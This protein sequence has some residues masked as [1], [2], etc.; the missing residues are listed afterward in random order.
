MGEVNSR[1]TTYGRR[2]AMKVAVAA[3]TSALVLAGA[4]ACSNSARSASSTST[5]AQ[6]Q[7]A[8]STSATASSAGSPAASGST[9]ASSTTMTTLRLV[10]TKYDAE[11]L[12]IIAGMERGVFKKH[13]IDLQVTTANTS[14]IATSALISNR[15]DL[16]LMQAAFVVSA[17]A[18]GAKIQLIGQLLDQLDYHIITAKGIK[19]L[20]ALAGQKMADPG[21]NNGNTATLKAVMDK[22]GIGADK[23]TYVTVGAQS[24]ILAAIEQNQAQVGL[25]VAPFTIQAR[26][27]GLNDLGTVEKYLPNNTAAAFAAMPNTLQSKSAAV[28]EFLAAVLESAQWVAQNSSAAIAMLV[29]DDKLTQQVATEDYNEVASMYTK[30][31]AIDPAG[32]QAWIEVATKYGV[33][34][35]AVPASSLYT[36][37]YLPKS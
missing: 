13:G 32:L 21:P 6:T 1:R 20:S 9:G 15:A 31:G 22:A 23:L 28:K 24:A 29:K 30:T 27:A 17:D 35:N 11:E 26:D 12:P 33:M 7:G 19:S 8:S 37:A 4:A 14:S 25:L 34:K 16:A 3:T 18:A 5:A 10:N 36:D 2:G